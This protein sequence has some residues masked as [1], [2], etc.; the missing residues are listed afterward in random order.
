MSRDAQHPAVMD[1]A[2]LSA[3]ATPLLRR[4][5]AMSSRMQY[6]SRPVSVA[7]DPVSLVI[8]ECI[9]ITSAIQKHAR[10]PNSSV[11]AILGGSPNL[12]QL[13]PPGP[14]LRR[15][16]KN[17]TATDPAV[18]GPADLAANRWGLRGK[19]GK[20]MQ[21]NPLISGFGRLRHE[22]TGV[23]DIH[24]FDSL[25]LLYPFLQII[26]AKGTAAPITVLALRAIQ[27]FLAYGFLSTTSPRFALAMQS[28]SAAITHCQFDI[29][30]SA[31]EE[32]VL[33]MILHLMEDMLS[34]PGGDILSDESVCDMMGRG[35]TICSRSRFSEV[36]RRTAEASM[37]RMC[38]IIFED[39]KH[40]E[41]EAGDESEA[42]DKQTIR[43]M[44]NVKMD[45]AANGTDVPVTT[46]ATK[47][48]APPVAQAP[49]EPRPSSGSEKA[50]IAEDAPG[51]VADGRSS[52]S[53]ATESND[54]VDLRPY[55]LPS[56][57][58]LFRVLVSFLNPHD[59]KHPDQ[60]RVMALRIIHVALEVAGPSIS[61]H[62][63]LATIAEDQLCSYLFQLVRSD[64][65]A[66]LQEALVVASTLLST[67]RGV[68]KL[69]QE[70]YLSYLVACLH[71]AVEIPREPGI[72]PSLYSGIPQA[73]KLVK[74][75]P[76]QANN[77]RVPTPVQV[78]DRQKL[79]MEGGSRKPD[80]RQAMVE[81]I[82]VL[83]RMPT[84]MVELFVNYD[85]DEDRADLCEDMIGLLSRNALPDSVTWSTTSVPPLCLDALLRFIQFIAERL[86]Q[87]PETEGYPDPQVLRE[88]RRR[89]KLIIKGTTK[90]NENPKGGL[91][92][93]QDK[94]IIQNAADP[95]CVAAFIKGTSRINKKV[96]GEFLS[97]KGN[98]PILDVFMDMFEFTGKRV[99]EALRVLLESF[100]LPGESALIERIVSSFSEKYCAN[101][102]PEDVA[103]KDAVFVLTYAIILLNTDQHNP[104]IKNR[105]SLHDFSRNLRGVNAGKDFA[106]E[107][108]QSIYDGIK[109]DEIIL[110]EEHDNRHAFDYAWKELL[111]KTESAGPLILCDTNLYDAD[112]FATAWNPI[113]SCLFFVFM[114]A[115]DD[116][117]YAR[118]I[119]GF[120]ECA[121]IATKYGNSEALDEI[122][123]RLSYISTLGGEALSNTSL[124]TEVQVGENSVM[125]SELAVKFGRDVRPQLATLVLFRVV[126]GSEHVIKNSWKHI[127]RIWINLFV[128]SLIP[129]FFSTEADKLSLPPIP[130]QNP[131]QVIDRGAKQSESGF[132][133]A[134]TSYISSYAADDPPEPSDEELES[135]LCTVD[136]VNQC[137]MGDVFANISNLPSDSLE[138]L[139][140]S[141]L[142]QIPD[143]N[144]ETV[145]S[146]KTENPAGSQSNG[147]KSR[148]SSAIYA[149]ALVY[150]LEFCTVLALRD[151][152]SVE[153]IGKR[154]V[155]AIQSVLRDTTRYHPILLERATFYLFNLLQASYDYDYVRVPVLLH[156][157]SSFSKDVLIKTST[158]VLRGLKLC[159]EKPCP[160][161][162]EIM[163]SPD[164]WVILQTL[165]TNTES[166][167]VVL[168]ILESGVSGTPSA[169]MADNYE[170]AIALLNE[171]ATMASVGAVAEQKSDRRPGRKSR[172][173]KQEKPSGSENV[174]VARG[175]KAINMISRMTSRIPHLM[176]QS[177]LESNEAWAAYWLPIFRALTTQCTNPCREVRHLAFASLQRS[178]L[179]P[180]LTSADHEE[181]TSIFGEVLFPLI[182]R[183][184]KPEVFSSDRDGM[185]ETRVQAASL[186][187]KV[188]LQYLVMLSKWEG[189]LDLWLRIIEIMD[190]LMNSGQGDSLEEAVPENLKNVLLIMSSNGYLVPPSKNPE[191]EE[192]WNET[193][194]RIDRFLPDL[195]NDL[196]LEEPA[197]TPPK[198]VAAAPAAVADVAS[199]SPAQVET[200]KE[201]KPR[202]SEETI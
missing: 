140:D 144:E 143:D 107:Y 58:E 16:R 137:H 164:F 146:V 75:P 42:L 126:T 20:S 65:M 159:I 5:P 170:A 99:D 165:A 103:D 39:L 141:L 127:I 197:E 81:N 184:L 188:F 139:V 22:L 2:L 152:K 149:P 111:L 155:E 153:L 194:K 82:G 172:P 201:A 183:L 88:R 44:D 131:S 195:R 27:K 69:Q 66:V 150:V 112:M 21:D 91:A 8:S 89:K 96:L 3:P 185:S 110:P 115:T 187:S 67:C 158:L 125:V 142:D 70:L 181:W 49:A 55:S 166:A 52:T 32:V 186:L 157:V 1:L 57:R 18:D 64:N 48:A 33:L 179:S 191:R 151:Q 123:Y 74:P 86:D 12:I 156:T 29:S 167:P 54:S 161:R 132:F 176:K 63:A 77:G 199:V 53:S 76:S 124:N 9:A 118:V 173:V 7:V 13:V 45:P 177:H 62:P 41:V 11:S 196:A 47:E 85:C 163:T 17:S 121:R 93:L 148:Q 122:I 79:G 190:R 102:T 182:H 10:S 198:V 133:S 92:Y 14:G 19:K 80:A 26:Q 56:V 119:T 162:N 50:I 114:S 31:Q 83:V 51:N 43:H 24:K 87:T 108:L 129:P 120:D 192:L 168:E 178:L 174:I 100:R 72:D 25:V 175:I 37:V 28:L 113:V 98:E 35:L 23:K 61:R 30:D 128:N 109:S 38:Q 40:L 78:K 171:F 106:P 84:F 36:L 34:G 169:I 94:G 160:L 68:L 202:E 193:W 117:V 135:T 4:S 200:E 46:Q 6:R 59:R 138:A 71:P 147:Q 130:L 105:M 60:M 101:S 73:P 104:T 15:D 116:T 145:I 90:F 97:K 180:E 136:C 134:F 154:V 95:K 189:M